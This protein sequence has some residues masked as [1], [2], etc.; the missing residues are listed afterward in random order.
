MRKREKR[1]GKREKNNTRREREWILA[2]CQVKQLTFC[3][4]DILKLRSWGGK[5][6]FPRLQPEHQ[7]E[8][9]RHPIHIWRAKLTQEWK[10]LEFK[11]SQLPALSEY[12]HSLL[13][14][15]RIW[16]FQW[17]ASVI[18]YQRSF[19]TSVYLTKM[20]LKLSG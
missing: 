19:L 14:A 18:W 13:I 16:G 2:I 17:D 12:H 6:L 15:R 8:G 3:K 7:P 9:E 4:K 20:H 11:G 10:D 5:S 1:E